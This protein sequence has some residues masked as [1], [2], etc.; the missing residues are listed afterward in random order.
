M[1]IRV[2]YH[3]S[4]FIFKSINSNINIFVCNNYQ[5]FIYL[6]TYMQF[7]QPPITVQNTITIRLRALSP[8]KELNC[9]TLKYP[10]V[11]GTS[12]MKFLT[13]NHLFIYLL[14]SRFYRKY[15]F[16]RVKHQRSDSNRR[17]CNHDS[18][19]KANHEIRISSIKQL[20]GSI[21]AAST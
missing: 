15:A 13:N 3:V 17:Q 7:G 11:V 21:S 1:N 14:L 8:K 16:T 6:S 5:N 19:H 2:H 4:L 12:L 18:N 20:L 10:L 9:S